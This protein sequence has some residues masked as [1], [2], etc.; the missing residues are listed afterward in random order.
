MTKVIDSVYEYTYQT[1]S[2]GTEG[3]YIVTITTTVDGYET[4]KQEFFDCYRPAP[5]STVNA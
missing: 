3:T 5:F 1:L 4:I 2:T